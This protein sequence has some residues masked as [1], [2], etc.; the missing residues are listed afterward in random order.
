[1]QCG[2]F[3]MEDHC[4][5][6]ECDSASQSLDA[7]YRTID[8]LDLRRVVPIKSALYDASCIGFWPGSRKLP[9]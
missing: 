5:V 6:A 2:A 9:L 8:L 4:L 3:P 7:I 1:M